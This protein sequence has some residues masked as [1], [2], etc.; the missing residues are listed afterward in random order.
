MHLPI[1]ERDKGGKDVLGR[2]YSMGEQKALSLQERQHAAWTGPFCFLHAT[3]AHGLT[4]ATFS[5]LPT[6]PLNTRAM[7]SKSSHTSIG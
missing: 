4:I 2:D 6:V 3:R 1:Y 7:I 5:R